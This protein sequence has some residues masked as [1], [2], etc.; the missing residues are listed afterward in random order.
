MLMLL[1]V[2]WLRFEWVKEETQEKRI[3]AVLNKIPRP[4]IRN[5]RPSRFVIRKAGTAYFLGKLL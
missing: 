1:K 4:A 5:S 3:I 2:E